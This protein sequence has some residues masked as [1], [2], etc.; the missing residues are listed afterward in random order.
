MDDHYFFSSIALWLERDHFKASSNSPASFNSCMYT[1]FNCGS[2]NTMLC[3]CTHAP[4][5]CL[6][7]QL[8][9]HG[10]RA[11]GRWASLRTSS[12]PAAPVS[13]V[14]D[15]TLLSWP[16]Y[17]KFTSSSFWISNEPNFTLERE[18]MEALFFSRKSYNHLCSFSISHILR[19][20]PHWGL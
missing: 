8:A 20:N 13:G 17:M 9:S 4:W 6:V 11:V 7:H 2:V 1:R 12:A 10:H 18:K 5:Q 16:F 15:Y 19:L 14:W 3:I